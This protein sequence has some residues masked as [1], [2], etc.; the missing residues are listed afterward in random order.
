MLLR[1]VR[2]LRPCV[3]DGDVV[4]TAK[5][6]LEVITLCLKVIAL[7]DEVPFDPRKRLFKTAMSGI[8]G[9]RLA[10]DVRQLFHELGTLSDI[11]DECDRSAFDLPR[12]VQIVTDVLCDAARKQGFVVGLD[13][14]DRRHIEK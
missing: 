7:L 3:Q 4:A 6:S 13:K 9:M 8:L 14:P 11:G 5:I 12:R 1:R 10:T 2:A